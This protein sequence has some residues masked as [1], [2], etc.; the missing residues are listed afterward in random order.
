V[1]GPTNQGLKST[2]VS[3]KKA[4]L[5]LGIAKLHAPLLSENLAWT[6]CEKRLRRVLNAEGLVNR[7]KRD[8]TASGLSSSTVVLY[9]SSTLIEGLDIVK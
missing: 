4:H 1:V 6:V 5:T 7:Q 2:V 3:L 9:L 8:V